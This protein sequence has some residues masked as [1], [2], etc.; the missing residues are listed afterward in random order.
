MATGYEAV[1][2]S[3]GSHLNMEDSSA[4]NLKLDCAC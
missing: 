2:L 4:A 3:F 1:I